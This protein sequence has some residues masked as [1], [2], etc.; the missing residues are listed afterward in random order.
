M[1]LLEHFRIVSLLGRNAMHGLYHPHGPDGASATGPNTRVRP[2]ELMRK[3]IGR[4]LRVLGHSAGVSVKAAIDRALIEPCLGGL[5]LVADT[6]AC[7]GD[8]PVSGLGGTCHGFY[9]Y[10]PVPASDEG[11]VYTAYLELLGVVVLIQMLHAAIPKETLESVHGR[12]VV[13]YTGER[14]ESVVRYTGERGEIHR[15]AW[16]VTRESVVRYTGGACTGEIHG[17]GVASYTGGVWQVTRRQAKTCLWQNSSF[18]TQCKT[19]FPPVSTLGG[20]RRQV[21]HGRW[22]GGRSEM[23]GNFMHLLEALA[24]LG[25]LEHPQRRRCQSVGPHAARR[26]RHDLVH[27][28]FRGEVLAACA[29]HGSE[30]RGKMRGAIRGVI[31][32]M[33]RDMIR[34][35]R[36]DTGQHARWI[37][38]KKVQ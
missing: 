30:R 36:R 17:R 6:D 21:A 38:M 10:M 29:P 3:Q 5:T 20:D 16:R 24:F 22:E 15:R 11:V 19:V 32:G 8:E 2:T 31:R 37:R 28:V 27:F 18:E 26:L 7:H 1:G 35:K 34:G 33:I 25:A 12:G 9:W 14:R 13:R 4:W 23:R